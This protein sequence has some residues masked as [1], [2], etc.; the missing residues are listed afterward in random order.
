M[1]ILQMDRR[2]Q[3][4]VIKMEKRL[5][6][7]IYW[8]EKAANN[9]NTIIAMQNLGNCYLYG[10]GVEKNYNKAFELFK[11]SAEGGYSGGMTS[12]GYCYDKG[13]GIKI[14]KQKAF[15][16]YQK[17]ADLGEIVA[18]Y[19]L[20]IMYENGVG[21][22]KDIDK[23]YYWCEKSAKQEDPDAQNK[24]KNKK[25]FLLNRKV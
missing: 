20:G 10:E 5:K 1:K 16:L 12:L 7:A 11:Q 8:Y 13:I 6:K 3:D 17:S 19:N 15:E 4:I 14:D 9:G 25:K 18:Q 22:T 23:A 24:I 21:I 2:I